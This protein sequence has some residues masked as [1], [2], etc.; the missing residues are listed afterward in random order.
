LNFEKGKWGW[1][2]KLRGGTKVDFLARKPEGETELPRIKN[3]RKSCGPNAAL[4]LTT[5]HLQ[6]KFE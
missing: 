6:G 5:K 3:H 2:G 4:L 1:R